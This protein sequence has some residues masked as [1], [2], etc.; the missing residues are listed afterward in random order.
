[1]TLRITVQEDA[2]MTTLKLEGRVVGPSTREFQRA[3][4]S[5]AASLGP[6]R[7]LVDLCGVT[8][9]D[10]DG[11]RVLAEIHQKTNADFLADTPMNKY[12]VQQAKR[13]GGGN[14]KEGV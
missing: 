6:R 14:F 9:M 3:W 7:L 4:E 5:V 11:T 2:G 1:M 13:R 12:F 8:H 10:A